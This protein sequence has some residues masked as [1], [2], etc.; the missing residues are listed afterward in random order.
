MF[1]IL[2]LCA[3]GFLAF[4]NP[5][6]AGGTA[7]ASAFDWNHLLQVV[8]AALAAYFGGKHGSSNQ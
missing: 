6:F 5:A 7:N 1:N 8:F 2:A 3:L 4:T